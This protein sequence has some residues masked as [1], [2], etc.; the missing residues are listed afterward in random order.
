MPTSYRGGHLGRT[1]TSRSHKPGTTGDFW[2]NL[3]SASQGYHLSGGALILSE[4]RNATF[5]ISVPMG[6]GGGALL[7]KGFGGLR[8]LQVEG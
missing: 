7:E 6:G 8:S 3:E 5:L 4:D 1:G 2:Y